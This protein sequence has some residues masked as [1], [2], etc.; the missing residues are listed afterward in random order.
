MKKLNL[1]SITL[2]LA[3]LLSAIVSMKEW[4]QKDEIYYAGIISIVLF[5]FLLI[6]Y[7]K[8]GK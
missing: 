4:I 8:A 3:I 6:R 7:I 2:S 5:S 1:F